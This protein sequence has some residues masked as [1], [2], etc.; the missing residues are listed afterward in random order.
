[1][2]LFKILRP[3]YSISTLGSLTRFSFRFSPTHPP[4][5]EM[6][7]T[8][9]SD[10][11]CNYDPSFKK[12]TLSERFQFRG[13]TDRDQ[14]SFNKV[15][16]LIPG[17]INPIARLE[18]GSNQNISNCDRYR[19]TIEVTET[20]SLINIEM[21]TK[22]QEY[23]ISEELYER[24]MELAD[25]VGSRVFSPYV[26]RKLVRDSVPHSSIYNN[27]VEMRKYQDGVMICGERILT[28][29][30]KSYRYIP[31]PYVIEYDEVNTP[32]Y[33]YV[34]NRWYSY[35]R[36]GD[37]VHYK[38][39]GSDVRRLIATLP[40]SSDPYHVVSGPTFLFHPGGCIL[41]DG[42]YSTGDVIY[43]SSSLIT[44][45]PA[46]YK[47]HVIV[48]NEFSK[49][50]LSLFISTEDQEKYYNYY[51]IRDIPEEVK[52][53]YVINGGIVAVTRD[54]S[55]Y[56][57]GKHFYRKHPGSHLIYPLSDTIYGFRERGID[58]VRN[59]FNSSNNFRS[60]MPDSNDSAPGRD[61]VKRNPFHPYYSS[62]AGIIGLIIGQAMYERSGSKLKL[63]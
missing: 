25:D 57:I 30:L 18:I 26:A 15:D 37:K 10:K 3:G 42:S 21:E 13:D 60:L 47:S 14:L 24:S 46:Y 53:L 12:L 43:R 16:I 44:Y 29:D 59:E 55:K 62:N 63:I 2:A 19:L 58:L 8:G 31:Y 41:S 4:L 40:T 9:D 54:G 51:K 34:N 23:D 36:I 56:V 20:M 7:S 50:V 38:Y 27:A 35:V 17:D 5:T 48:K 49:N 61:T 33:D 45:V 39:I 28:P 22:G 32:Y 1:M 11:R 6:V 52:I